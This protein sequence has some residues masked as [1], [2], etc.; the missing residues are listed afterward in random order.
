KAH[1]LDCTV[2]LPPRMGGLLNGTLDGKAPFSSEVHYDVADEWYDSEGNQLRKRVWDDESD[3]RGMRLIRRI[4]K[5]PLNEEASEEL[6]PARREW[7]WFVCPRLADDEG[8]RV[9][10]IKVDLATHLADVE[11]VATRI[12]EA[13]QLPSYLRTA[14]IVAARFHDLG[15][16]HPLWQ[17]SI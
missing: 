8:S 9:S 12:A 6:V 15:K 13:L 16:V 10:L 1:I 17:R 14:L 4:D 3:P 2:L 7:R 5:H 11:R